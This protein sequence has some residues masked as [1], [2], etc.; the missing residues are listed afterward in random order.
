MS[1][2]LPV[3]PNLVIPAELLRVRMSRSGGAGGQHVN[4]ADTR[5]Q[6]FFAL[7]QWD[8]LHP[9]TR[10]RIRQANR[11]RLTTDGELL[12]S[13]GSNRS[14]LR[15]VEEVR[16]RLAEIIRQHLKPPKP[17]RKTKPSRS[18]QRKRMDKKKRR[19][20]DKRLRGRVKNDW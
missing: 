9:Q 2:D 10:D 6:L 16:Q 4:T 19:G 11:N 18:S 8:D 7:D 1:E 12:L 14:R 5:V 13:C 15:N 20:A 3:T 17:R